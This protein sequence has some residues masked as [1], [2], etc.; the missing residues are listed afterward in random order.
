MIQKKIVAG[1]V[2]SEFIRRDEKA[3]PITDKLPE[4]DYKRYSH[5]RVPHSRLMIKELKLD[6]SKSS[7]G[8]I[9]KVNDDRGGFTQGVVVR[10]GEG[11]IDS[12]GRKVPM[13]YEVGDI[14]YFSDMAG[15]DYKIMRDQGE[16]EEVRI[17]DDQ[18]IYMVDNSIA[19]LVF[20]DIT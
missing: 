16:Y 4:I 20:K 15:V 8:I 10:V 5:I 18:S 1:S 6:Y 12:S 19:E 2:N 3:V 11:Y 14:V 9:L 7:E 17:T 13:T